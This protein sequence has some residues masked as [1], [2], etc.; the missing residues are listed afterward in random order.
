[1]QPPR[2]LWCEDGHLHREC[3]GKDKEDSTPACCRLQMLQMS[4]GRDA[5][6]EHSE[7]THTHTRESLLQIHHVRH[8]L[9]RGSTKQG[10]P[11]SAKQ[12]TPWCSGSSSNRGPTQSSYFIEMAAS[13][14][15]AA[16]QIVNSSPL[17]NTVRVV[18]VV[19]STTVL[20]Q[21]KLKYRPYLKL[22]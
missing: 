9:R 8:V 15:S 20:C 17:D 3:P 11:N 5:S 12:S 18:T 1:M 7:D 6:E 22:Y 4:E 14:S 19:Q 2:C 13:R 16:A 21:K 10:R